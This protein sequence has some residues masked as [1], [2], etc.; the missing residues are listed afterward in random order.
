MSKKS[1]V[2]LGASYAG[3]TVAHKLLK[4]T[5]PKAQNFK[6]V[7]VSPSNHFFWNMASPRGIIPGLFADDRLFQSFLPG[8]EKYPK[9]SFEFVEG[10][11]SAVDVEKKVVSVKAND[12]SPQTLRYDMLVIA[13]G[14]SSTEHLP[15]K[16]DGSHKDTLDRLHALQK[17]V[18]EA[19]SIVVGGGGATGVET[20]GE[21][22][23]EYFGKGKWITLITNDTHVLPSLREDVGAFAEKELRRLGVRITTNAKVTAARPYGETQTELHLSD[24]STLLTDLYIPTTGVHPN[25]SFLPP[26]L[27]N[28]TTHDVLTDTHLRVLS[29]PPNTVFAAGDCIGIETKQVKHAED[30]AVHL[31]AN[32]DA[33]L[34]AGA[35]SAAGKTMKEYVPSTTQMIAVTLGRSKGTGLIA[36][37][38]VWSWLVWWLKGR[39]MGTDK[40]ERMA[41]GQRLVVRGSV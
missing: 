35:G 15:F 9:E 13:T 23:F 10:A 6:V 25:T 40:L 14:A 38:R 30:Q 27:L 34:L 20:A 31:A 17:R 16:Q 8:F 39:W 5:Y 11:A 12:G 18:A 4:H 26:D 7:L 33:L 2:V 19:S 3:L 1:V 37:W 29:T 32:L 28:P 21:L 22:G 36:S 24:G 41:G